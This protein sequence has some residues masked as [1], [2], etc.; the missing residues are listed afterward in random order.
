[1][2]SRKAVS[3]RDSYAP[4]RI[5]SRNTATKNH[6]RRQPCHDFLF[7]LAENPLALECFAVLSGRFLPTD[8]AAGRGNTGCILRPRLW[9]WGKRFDQNRMNPYRRPPKERSFF[10]L[11]ARSRSIGHAVYTGDSIAIHPAFATLCLHNSTFYVNFTPFF[12]Q[13][14][15]LLSLFRPQKID[16]ICNQLYN[17]TCQQRKFEEE[18]CYE[19]VPVFQA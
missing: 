19:R 4:K 8:T 12:E 2:T 3:H 15:N 1:M 6:G 13:I 10:D 17:H 5:F 18:V 11:P 7:C 16:I 9:L 14:Y